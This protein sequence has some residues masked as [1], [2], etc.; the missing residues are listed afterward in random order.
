M[1]ESGLFSEVRDY[2]PFWAIGG[3]GG[4]ITKTSMWIPN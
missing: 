2:G 1:I 4:A 3:G